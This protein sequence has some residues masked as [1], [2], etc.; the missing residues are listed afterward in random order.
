[1]YKIFQWLQIQACEIIQIQLVS[2]TQ[3]S[4]GCHLLHLQILRLL[5]HTILQGHI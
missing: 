2:Q 1:M 3:R 5:V 4:L